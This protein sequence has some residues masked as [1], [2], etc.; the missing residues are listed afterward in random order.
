ML[1]DT[2]MKDVFEFLR[3]KLIFLNALLLKQ[4]KKKMELFNINSY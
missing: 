2:Q 1:P 4:Q 3:Q